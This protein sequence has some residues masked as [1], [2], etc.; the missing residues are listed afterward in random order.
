MAEASAAIGSVMPPRGAAEAW[1]GE[2]GEST[3]SAVRAAVDTLPRPLPRANRPSVMRLAARQDPAGRQDPTGRHVDRRSAARAQ[4]GLESVGDRIRRSTTALGTHT[5]HPVA[6]QSVAH[7][8]VAGTSTGDGFGSI[9]GSGLRGPGRH[10]ATVSRS[11]DGRAVQWTAPTLDLDTLASAPPTLGN[12]LGLGTSPTPSGAP[13]AGEPGVVQ[14]LP[15]SIDSTRPVQHSAD[16]TRSTTPVAQRAATALKARPTLDPSPTG[17]AVDAPDMHRS[18]HR[19]VQPPADV[20][21]DQR[22]D[23]DLHAMRR[24]VAP[25]LGTAELH[26]PD[27]SAPPMALVRPIETSTTGRIVSADDTLAAE[28]AATLVSADELA[29][30]PPQHRQPS[31]DSAPSLLD[32]SST[33]TSAVQRRLDIRPAASAPAPAAPSA[34]TT[35]TQWVSARPGT[36]FSS[37]TGNGMLLRR[38]ARRPLLDPAQTDNQITW[39]G[40][41]A[42]RF[43]RIVNRANPIGS[44]PTDGRSIDGGQNPSGLNPSGPTP[45]AANQ[46]G[47][48]PTAAAVAPTTAA[49]R[50]DP[51]IIA[52]S[53]QDHIG[54]IPA[55]APGDVALSPHD[56]DDIERAANPVQRARRE[57]QQTPSISQ[58][59]QRAVSAEPLAAAHTNSVG[60]PDLGNAGDNGRG[61]LDRHL[62]ASVRPAVLAPDAASTESPT[63]TATD[64]SMSIQRSLQP[65]PSV[66]LAARFLAELSRHRQEAA[67][68]LPIQFSSIADMIVGKRKPLI[69]TSTASRKALAAVGKVAATTGDTIHLAEAP[70][71]RPTAE[72]AAVIAHELTHVAAPSPA[73]RF[74]DDDRHSSEES[75]ATEMGDLMRR[76]PMLPNIAAAVGGTIARMPVPEIGR[77][78][79]GRSTSSASASASAQTIRRAVDE[80]PDTR[81]MAERIAPFG[82]RGGRSNSSSSTSSPTSSATTNGASSMLDNAPTP[83]AQATYTI[84]PAEFEKNLRNNFDLIVELLEDRIIADL[85]RRGG[86]FRGDF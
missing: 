81:T 55:V 52:R 29:V 71:A 20:V 54:R 57:A 64:A 1:A 60:A 74:F 34:A 16:P 40:L 49:G 75:R 13:T 84:D 70:T 86:R 12:E 18:P 42:I 83:S 2:H 61:M 19:P 15:V 6:P 45:T 36:M 50:P 79:S 21:A 51:S 25:E 43:D 38:S 30:R 82:S 41:E 85:E 58:P 39:P 48:S 11:L 47:P 53:L 14:R 27:R 24:S 31:A 23:A 44:F 78:A 67:R 77:P 68:P 80:S 3:D 26:A 72:M 62:L 8:A 22:T 7:H 76:T 59:L 10:R 63:S 9:L 73:P 32:D 37:D 33:T 5:S 69:S 56:P 4:T 46:G 65:T 66:D 17:R 28:I 35:P